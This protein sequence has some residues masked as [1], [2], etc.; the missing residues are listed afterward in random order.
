MLSHRI[1]VKTQ[2]VAFHFQLLLL[3]S[4]GLALLIEWQALATVLLQINLAYIS[5][6]LV[7]LIEQ[8]TSFFSKPTFLMISLLLIIANWINFDYVEG[9]YTNL[10]ILFGYMFVQFRR[11]NIDHL[12]E[13]GTILM[14]PIAIVGLH[15]LATQ[16]FLF[17]EF[18]WNAWYAAYLVINMW[19][20]AKYGNAEL[21]THARKYASAAVFIYAIMLIQIPTKTVVAIDPLQLFNIH[22]NYVISIY[23]YY[24]ALYSALVLVMSIYLIY[25]RPVV[26]RLALICASLV[27]IYFVLVTSWRPVWLAVSVG[28]LWLLLFYEKGKR[29]KLLGILVFSQA[30]LLFSNVGHYGSRLVELIEKISTEERVTIWKDA[31]TMQATSSPTQWI[32]GHGLNSYLEDFQR[33]STY[34][35]QIEFRSPHNI[36]L[37]LLYTSG[38]AGLTIVAIYYYFLIAYF[39]K[40]TRLNNAYRLLACA[41]LVLL[42][43]NLVVNGLNFPFFMRTNI[44]PLA[45]ICG[46]LFYLKANHSNLPGLLNLR[47]TSLSKPIVA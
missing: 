31:F 2:R 46:I 27:F 26:I 21:V 37:D 24:L 23:T 40:A 5:L 7:V 41:V 47:G 14:F 9:L 12:R 28:S 44:Y 25:K 20:L 13:L 16:S 3:A 39:I 36:V 1:F 35:K 10:G 18:A 15:M 30:V 19:I 42:T 38:V 45:Y 22:S 17:G 32:Y 43:V 29:L 34:H 6:Y 8:E 11:N 4:I 33:Y